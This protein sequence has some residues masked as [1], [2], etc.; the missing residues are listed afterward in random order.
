MF[1]KSGVSSHSC[2]IPL[3][4]QVKGEIFIG[5]KISI[6]IPV[7]NVES[8]ITRCLQSV[9]KQRHFEE[10]EVIVVNDG[11][12]DKSIDLIQ[13]AVGSFHNIEIIHQANKGLSEARNTGIK[14]AAG[15]YISFVDSDDWIEPEMLSVMYERAIQNQ[16]DIV[17]CEMRKVME[18]NIDEFIEIKSG[19]K[20][21]WCFVQTKRFT[22]ILSTKK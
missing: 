9:I 3:K 11:S 6:I 4:Q 5:P 20:K 18:E 22:I 8:Y 10:F 7:Y 14:A 15:E 13:D 16:S 1:L 2:K 19:F 12:T 17:V 21:K